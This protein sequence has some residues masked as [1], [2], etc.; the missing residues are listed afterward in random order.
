MEAPYIEQHVHEKEPA[1]LDLNPTQTFR[2][3]L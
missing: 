2:P 1:H 3:K